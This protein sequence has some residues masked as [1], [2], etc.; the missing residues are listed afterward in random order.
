MYIKKALD[1]KILH[2]LNALEDEFETLWVEINTGTKS[3]NIVICCAHRHPD[4]DTNKFIEYLE[5]TLSK[6]DKNKIIC[7]MGDVNI[8][9][10]NYESHNETSEFINSMVSHY[11]LPHIL[12]PIRV[13]D[14]SATIIDNIFTNATEFNT[15]SGNILNQLADHFSQFLVIKKLPITHKDAAYYQ[16][17]YSNFDK[18][19][20]LAD[21]SKINW[22]DTQNLPDDVNEEF[23]IFHEKVSQCV[24][25]HVPLTKLSRKK[26]SLRSKP[27]I[28]VKIEQIWL[29]GT[30]T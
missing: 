17:D 23:S 12:Q 3:T 2:D 26:I 29:K 14:H 15:V 7:V 27:W 4:T 21:F 18:S 24:R 1:H 8:N 20:L 16:Y 28:S 22:N 30:S 19:K 6:V 11:L 9:L 5:A 25:N 13:T 10:L